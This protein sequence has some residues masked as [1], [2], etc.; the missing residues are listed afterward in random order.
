VGGDGGQS[1]NFRDGLEA[2]TNEEIIEEFEQGRMPGGSFHH[3][4][5]IRVAFTYLSEFSVLEALQ[6]FCAA[7][8]RFATAQGKPDLYHE[9]ITWAYLFLIRERMLRIEHRQTWEEFAAANQDLLTWERGKSGILSQ[10]YE[11]ETLASSVARMTFLLPD[12]SVSI[13]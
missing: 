8:K 11:T 12:K 2:M 10:Y 3:A 9:T 4:D 5:H 6:R 13:S 7:L 1:A